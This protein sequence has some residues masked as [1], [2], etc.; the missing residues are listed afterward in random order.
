[1]RLKL[2]LPVISL[3]L[4]VA[5]TQ[6]PTTPTGE[7]VIEEKNP[8]S[9]ITCNKNQHCV[10]GNCVCDDGFKNCDDKCIKETDCCTNKECEK[11]EV[12]KDNK[13]IFDCEKILCQYNEV[14]DEDLKKCVCKPGTR[15]CEYQKKCFEFDK[16]CDNYDCEGNKKCIITKFSVNICFEG[17]QTACKWVGENSFVYFNMFGKRY[18]FALDKIYAN[19][20]IKYSIDDATL[21]RLKLRE[22]IKLQPRLYLYLQEIKEIG[23]IC[24]Y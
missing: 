8:C 1:M 22:R 23:G 21:Q 5:C 15:F 3:F 2:L 16:C 19:N 4:L 12:C 6:T 13:C 11:D 9:D 14:C 20:E 17:E 18:K 10:N 24:E 7:T